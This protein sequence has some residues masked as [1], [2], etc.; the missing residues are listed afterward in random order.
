MQRLFICG[1]IVNMQSDNNFIS[2]DLSN[3]IMHSDYAVCNFEGPEVLPG[4]GVRC[5]HQAPGT[6]RYLK[7]HGF[8]L[9]L[10]ANNHITELGA[11]GLSYTINTIKA[12][13]AYCM[14]AG[15]SWDETYKTLTREIGGKV[16]GFINV[17]EAQDGHFLSQKQS[18]G[19]AWLGYPGLMGDISHLASTTDYVVV[20]VHA[21]LE[22][23]PIPLPE[24][25][26]FYHRICDAGASCVVA[27]HPHC[28]QGYEFYGNKPIVYSLGNFF[29]PRSN[30]EW[31]EENSSYSVELVFS[32]TGNIELHPVYH[33]LKEGQV[34]LQTADESSIDLNYLCSLL[35][36]NYE[37]Y[38]KEMCSTAYENLCDKLLTG[39]FCGQSD[40]DGWKTVLINAY[41]YTLGRNKYIKATK[42]KRQKLLL[43]MYENETYRWVITRYLRNKYNHE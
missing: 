40:Q 24:I 28:A 1:D 35:N 5:P 13:G 21:G 3:V 42:E 14:G 39:S 23:Y 8:D 20:F 6:A 16:F 10:L 34:H 18:Y 15:E 33:C 22:H 36:K 29:F 38:A 31:A 26:D 12:A 11:E 9:L 19:Y 32:E 4:Q 2:E 17:C 41:R 25:R 30:G 27:S 37:D 7:D 43:R